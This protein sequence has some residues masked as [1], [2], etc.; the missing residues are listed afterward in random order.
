L[1]L[2]GKNNESKSKISAA[3]LFFS[4]ILLIASAVLIFY[5]VLHGVYGRFDT[6]EM[7]PNFH[8]LESKL[9]RKNKEAAI[10]F[11]GYTQNM[12]P[13]DGVWIRNNISTW[14]KF[15]NDKNASYDVIND[16][17][18]EDGKISNYDVLILP[19]CKSLSD[20]EIVEIK[21]YLDSGGS[22][23][24]TGGTATYS[25]NGKW[26]GWDFFSQVFG[27]KFTQEIQYDSLTKIHT[28]RGGIPLTANIPTGFHLRVATWDV[29]IEVE[30]L[31]PRTTQVSYWY[32]PN[33]K[34][35]LVREEIKNSAGIVNGNY[36]KGRFVWMGFAINS[37]IGS[38]KDYVNFEKL[39]NNSINWLTHGPV[40]YIKDWPNGY[41][42]AAIFVSSISGNQ[43]NID[44]LTAILKANN[45]KALFYISPDEINKKAGLIVRLSKFGDVIPRVIISSNDTSNNLVNYQNEIAFL[46]NSRLKLEE[47][48]NKKVHGIYLDSTHI[49]DSLMNHL[50]KAG[51]DYFLTDSAVDRSVPQIYSTPSGDLIKITRASRDDQYIVKKLG[52]RN[53]DF[54]F[55][56]YQEDVD[57][58]LFEGG[59][60]ICSIH[61][62]IQMQA[63]YVSVLRQLIDNIN[64]K[65]IWLTNITEVKNWYVKRG[66]I[67]IKVDRRGERRVA[68]NVTNLGMEPVK[69]L[70]INLDLNDNSKNISV[71]EEIIGTKPIQYKYLKDKRIVYFHIKELGP[72]ESRTYYVDYDKINI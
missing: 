23:F 58:I 42:A 67:E 60:Y 2:D 53:P 55:Y 20:K 50:S 1:E 41:D 26:R 14:E 7:L 12:L 54:Q 15:L 19:G 47:I 16:Q 51:F 63:Q 25:D 70:I 11:S 22:I 18:I 4:G 44:S 32:D 9:L 66:N 64:Q 45:L 69:D 3:K 13:S 65:N 43:Q 39:F 37:I 6:S 62:E 72:H 5:Y 31:D 33:K 59:L 71:D 57:K 10:L 29:P 48:L 36:G 27:I 28:L 61:P 8:I 17:T 68:F 40:A 49:N 21:K 30:V 34:G 24:A 52:L 56:T 38:R 35:G 46:K